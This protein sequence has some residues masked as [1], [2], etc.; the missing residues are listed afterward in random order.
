[1]SN[2]VM[3]NPML[4]NTSVAGSFLLRINS[5]YKKPSETNARFTY[6][7]VSSPACASVTSIS[8]LQFTMNRVFGNIYIGSNILVIIHSDGEATR[9]ITVPEG[10]Y[11]ITQ[12]VDTLNILVNNAYGFPELVFTWDT[13]LDRVAITSFNGDNETYT[14]VWNLS[15]LAPYI[16]ISTD[17]AIPDDQTVVCPSPPQL[18]GPDQIFVESQILASGQ[19]LDDPQ[20]T[21]GSI[22]LLGI[23]PCGDVP[24]GYTIN[25]TVQ[26]L[27]QTVVT[28]NHGQPGQLKRIDISITDKYGN[29]LNIPE[30]CYADIL[31][32]VTYMP[33]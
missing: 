16:G 28:T 25:Y 29:L 9:T 13:V 22:P 2:Y 11:T 3:Q 1:M 4:A 15:T 8:L 27:D 5:K 26:E 7:L 21:G 18:Q 31:F 33:N 12:L 19:C 6:D 24:Y 14:I 32:R 30:T 20:A 23:I 17:F 10:Q